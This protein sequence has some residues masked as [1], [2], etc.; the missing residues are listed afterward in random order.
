MIRRARAT[1]VLADHSKIG[2]VS[3]VS[4]CDIAEIDT[5]VTDRPASLD[6]VR[7]VTAR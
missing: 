3:R 1:V 4:I 6:G 2:E 7:V 5:V